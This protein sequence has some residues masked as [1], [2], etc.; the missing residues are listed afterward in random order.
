MRS[1]TPLTHRTIA[2]S[3]PQVDCQRRELEARDNHALL[4]AVS[5]ANVF[6]MP[7]AANRYVDI[8]GVEHS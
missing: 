5:G 6:T 3:V 7:D 8:D 4:G 1:L 2:A